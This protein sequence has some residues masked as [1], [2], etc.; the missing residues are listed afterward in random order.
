MILAPFFNNYQMNTD[1]YKKAKS[2]EPQI[3]N[4]LSD[5]EDNIED[6]HPR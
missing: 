2:K 4:L 5:D 1:Y 3:V 6:F